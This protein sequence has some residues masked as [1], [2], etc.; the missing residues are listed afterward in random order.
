MHRSSEST[1]TAKGYTLVFT[2]AWRWP[3]DRPAPTL[4]AL[5]AHEEAW[6]GWWIVSLAAVSH[7][8][9]TGWIRVEGLICASWWN[10]D[11]F[12]QREAQL[13]ERLDHALTHLVRET[14]CRGR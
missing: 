5:R 4:T 2:P 14:E 13:V 10:P 12:K 6:R 11:E 3:A 1:A 9:S 8:S 7:S